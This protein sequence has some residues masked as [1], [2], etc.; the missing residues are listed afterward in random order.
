[1]GKGF[2]EYRHLLDIDRRRNINSTVTDI[3][4]DLHHTPN[5]GLME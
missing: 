2:G 3:N 1:M 4:A 5:I